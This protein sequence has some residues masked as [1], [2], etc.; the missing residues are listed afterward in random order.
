DSPTM[1][2]VL[3]RSSAKETPSTALT[4]PSS[5]WKWIRRSRTSRNGLGIPGGLPA[6][7]ASAEPTISLDMLFTPPLPGSRQPYPRVDHRIEN[8]DDEVGDDDEERGEERDAHD[9]RQIQ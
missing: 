5:V 6:R 3:P 8:V 2:S 9:R 4:R 1:P 7:Y